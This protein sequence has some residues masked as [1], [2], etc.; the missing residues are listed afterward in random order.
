M[1]KGN[2]HKMIQMV[3]EKSQKSP[4]GNPQIRKKFARPN[5]KK[6]WLTIRCSRQPCRTSYQKSPAS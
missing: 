2:G 1:G 6:I 4:N 3:E 5:T